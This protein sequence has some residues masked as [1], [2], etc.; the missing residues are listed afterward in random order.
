MFE[1]Y[2]KIFIESYHTKINDKQTFIKNYKHCSAFIAYENEK[3]IGLLVYEDKGSFL[4]MWEFGL[5]P[6][7]QH[8]GVGKQFLQTFL[9][10]TKKEIRLITNPHNSP[11]II[12][13]LKHGFEI[14]EWKEKLFNNQPWIVLRREG[15][16]RV[17]GST[18][19]RLKRKR[20][21]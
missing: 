4:L 21:R 10:D 8:K 16:N 1:L 18:A 12:F 3:P 17:R 2:T 11:A 7:C 9:D 13:Y 15:K 6:E 14:S 19:V 20:S 5:L